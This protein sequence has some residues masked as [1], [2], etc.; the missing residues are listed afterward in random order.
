MTRNPGSGLI[1]SCRPA[2]AAERL[3]SGAL[4]SPQQALLKYAA[5]GAIAAMLFAAASFSPVDI[6][7]WHQMLLMRESFAAGHLVTGNFASYTSPVSTV[8]LHEWGAALIAYL[9]ATVAGSLGIVT[10]KYLIAFATGFS[11]LR[12]CRLSGG[13]IRIFC[14]LTPLAAILSSAGLMTNIRPQAYSFLFG[15][16]LLLMLE[17]DRQGRRLWIIGAL[18][19]FPVWANIHGGFVVGI[20]MLGCYTLEQAVRRQPFRHL[21]PLLPATALESLIHPSG[22][23]YVRYLLH[24][25]TMARPDI[26]EWA[27]VWTQQPAWLVL[28]GVAVA[29]ATYAIARAKAGHPGILILA[30]LAGE[31]LLHLKMLPF[32]ALALLCY[33][34]R[35]LRGSSLSAAILR[36]AQRRNDIVLT[37]CALLTAI[38]VVIPV[39][40][41]SWRLQ[42]PQD[43]YHHYPVGPVSYLHQQKFRGNLMTPFR[44]GAYVSWNLFP[45]VKISMDSRYDLAYPEWMTDENFRFYR[46]EP[47]WDLTLNKYATDAVLV[48]REAPLAR[49]IGTSGWK[50]VYVDDQFELYARP[51]ISLPVVDRTGT[52]FSGVFP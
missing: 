16:L 25:M 45:A 27:P 30:F 5:Y 21:L 42:V 4:S 28:Y 13:D 51:G 18:L 7:I 32:F 29:I 50:R 26:P 35:F 39:H 10:A 33:V 47:G 6:D 17:S 37:A 23:A 15:A 2:A 3:S 22:F 48:L 34:P 11:C 52:S 44:L 38:F 19:L 12:H 41:G 46:A 36:L 40:S 9:L 1:E 24:T 20:A 31:A 14:L 49:V 43:T 8:V